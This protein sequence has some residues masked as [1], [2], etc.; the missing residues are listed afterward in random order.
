MF[1]ISNLKHY[2]IL[3]LSEGKYIQ[4]SLINLNIVFGKSVLS[5]LP[6]PPEYHIPNIMENRSFT[7]HKLNLYFASDIVRTLWHSGLMF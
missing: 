6:M 2:K 5:S 7:A 4:F 1:I 3:I